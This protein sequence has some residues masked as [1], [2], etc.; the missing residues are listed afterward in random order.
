MMGQRDNIAIEVLDSFPVAHISTAKIPTSGPPGGAA[1]KDLKA[2]GELVSLAGPIEESQNL[3]HVP[4]GLDTGAVHQA[5]RR[6][7]VAEPVFREGLLNGPEVVT[8]QGQAL[9]FA[10]GFA[11]QFAHH[12]I[13]K[14]VH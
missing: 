3:H 12:P 2:F 13:A 9:A 14:R 1:A 4:H 6:G 10:T 11:D 8:D 7:L 5:R